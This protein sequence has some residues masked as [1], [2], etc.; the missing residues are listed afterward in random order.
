MLSFSRWKLSTQI[1]VQLLTQSE[2]E[3][4]IPSPPP[5][6]SPYKTLQKAFEK[7]KPLGAALFSGLILGCFF[8]VLL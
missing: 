2:F 8:R 7:R 3:M 4:Q 5:P 6:F 1:F